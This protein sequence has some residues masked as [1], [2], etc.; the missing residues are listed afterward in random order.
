MNISGVAVPFVL[1]NGDGEAGKSTQPVTLYLTITV[2]TNM[3]PPI[4]PGNPPEIPTKGDDTTAEETTKPSTVPAS[5]GPIQ[6]TAPEPLLPL[7]DPLPVETGAPMS[8]GQAEMS[9]TE[10]AL[11]ALRHADEDKKPIDRKNKWKGAV[12]RIK[13][14]M[15]TV[16]PIAEVRPISIFLSILSFLD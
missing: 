9:P 14:V 5:R 10:K 13:W 2:L 7:S 8:D 6:S 3:P 4:V 1:S 11:I 12:S 16:S 15:D